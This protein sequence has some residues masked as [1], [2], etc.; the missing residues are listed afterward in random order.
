MPGVISGETF[1]MSRALEVLPAR[2]AEDMFKFLT[3]GIY[4]GG[5][6]LDLQMRQVTFK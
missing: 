5:T 2:E 6:S 3:T 1:T 4:F